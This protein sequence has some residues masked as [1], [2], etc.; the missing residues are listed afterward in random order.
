[1]TWGNKGDKD[2]ALKYYEVALEIDKKF[3]PNEHPDVAIDYNNI[4][5]VLAYKGNFDKAIDNYKKALSIEK[6]FHGEEH[7]N[8]VFCY[9]NLAHC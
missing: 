3:Y 5:A 6:R 7:P 4:G 2:K 1:M 9:H 8:L